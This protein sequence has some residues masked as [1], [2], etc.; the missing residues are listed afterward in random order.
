MHQ[1]LKHPQ[2]WLGAMAVLALLLSAC[3]Q[4]PA[5]D[6]ALEEKVLK[7]LRDHPEVVLQEE[8]VV[9]ILRR[10]PDVVMESVSAYQQEERQK[11]A[12]AAAETV[13]QQAAGLDVA[14]LIGDSPVTGAPA[15]R[16]V[17]IEFSDFQC[18]YCGRA[19]ATVKQ[20]MDQHRDELTLGYK[21]LPLTEMHPEAENAARAAWAAQQQGKFWEYH[22]DLFAAQDKLGDEY[23]VALAKHHGLDLERFKRDRLSAEAGAA[24]NADIALA[25][26]LGINSTPLFL[27]NGIAIAGSVPLAEFDKALAKAEAALTK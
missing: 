21:H 24:I 8:Q 18:P 26:R 25:V 4:R 10:H 2:A 27:L 19:Q 11:R 16:L 7:I 6:K 17:L 12:K 22:D 23:Y 3:S 20:F 1:T 13:Q 15:R 9:D 14:E 5:D